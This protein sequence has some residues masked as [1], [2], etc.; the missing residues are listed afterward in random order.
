MQNYGTSWK[1][2]AADPVSYVKPVYEKRV[3][4]RRDA[5]E[6]NPIWVSTDETTD[7]TGR[8]VAHVIIG[9]LVP[10]GS[11]SFPI[12]AESLE[13]THSTAMA[14]VFFNAFSLLW[15]D[16]VQYDRVL[17]FLTDAAAYMRKAGRALEVSFPKMLN[18]TCA[19][20]ALHRVAEEIRGMYP[21]VDRPISNGKKIFLKAASRV[22][23]FRATVPGIPLPPQPILT[24]WGTWSNA[25]V[26]H[27]KY[28]EE[29]LRVIDK[30]DADDAVSIRA[31]KEMIGEQSIKHILKVHILKLRVFVCR[32]HPAR[33]TSGAPDRRD[34]LIF[35]GAQR[36]QGDL[37]S[38]G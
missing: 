33:R 15:P 8:F 27:A 5:V 19:A 32:N 11:A 17:L 38:R 7:V 26:Y 36:S 25:A 28:F 4:R 6:N 9:I 3:Q 10:T 24:G 34:G 29:F 1:N 23:I 37:R 21:N 22:T 16:G 14:Q 30:L 18:V 20:H 31:V 12:H 2:G 13:R 35:E